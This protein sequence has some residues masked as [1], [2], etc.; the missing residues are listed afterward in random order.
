MELHLVSTLDLAL[1]EYLCKTIWIWA[2]I[3]H[4]WRELHTFL[5]YRV[6][7]FFPSRI[8]DWVQL[9][10]CAYGLTLNTG[11]HHIYFLICLQNWQLFSP[12]K[13][14]NFWNLGVQKVRDDYADKTLLV[15]L[16]LELWIRIVVDVLEI[17]LA[18]L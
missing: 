18:L 17:L 11:I 10:K 12:R 3:S 9:T 5:F 6:R 15:K 4:M 16:P 13:F 14:A 7:Q 8:G 2:W 1:L